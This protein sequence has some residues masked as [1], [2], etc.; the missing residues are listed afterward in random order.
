MNDVRVREGASPSLEAAAKKRRKAPYI[1]TAVVVFVAIFVAAGMAFW[2]W[3][4]EPSFCAAICHDPMDEYLEGYEQASG[5]AGRDKWG[6][7]VSNTNAMMAVTHA[8]AGED[9]LSCHVPSLGQQVGELGLFVSG[10]FYD[11]LDEVTLNALQVNSG[12]AEGS[13]DQFCLKSGCHVSSDGTEITTREALTQ[14]TEDRAFNPHR[15]SQHGDI[16]CSSCHKSH[17]A[18]VMYCT[19]CHQDAYEDMPEGWVDYETGAQ[20]EESSLGGH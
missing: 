12:N 17:R 14:V 6:N 4:E 8:A 7:E 19:A 13:G 5:V 9:C 2:T 16:P 11:P 1:L 3:H 20:I 18:S 10:N 15:W